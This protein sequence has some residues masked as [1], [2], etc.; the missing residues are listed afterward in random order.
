MK[1]DCQH[2][3][4]PVH[5]CQVA[6]FPAEAVVGRSRS[7][8]GS[9][10]PSRPVPRGRMGYVLDRRRSIR[11][12]APSR[13]TEDLQQLQGGSPT[14][15]KRNP[16]TPACFNEPDERCA[17]IGA[18][19]AIRGSS[20]DCHCTTLV[21][22]IPVVLR[23]IRR[24]SPVAPCMPMLRVAVVVKPVTVLTRSVPA[25]PRRGKLVLLCLRVF[26]GE[27]G[28]SIGRSAMI[29]NHVGITSRPLAWHTATIRRKSS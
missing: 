19:G 14:S 16:S 3:R 1:E 23:W 4:H 25:N 18:C 8:S 9:R 24:R 29:D 20:A 12:L 6:E 5:V 15:S 2:C 21:P 17:R 10:C 7:D 27:S 28:V 13:H 26:E 11:R 22:E